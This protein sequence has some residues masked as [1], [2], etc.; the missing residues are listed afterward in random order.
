MGEITSITCD[1]PSANITML[2]CL[3]CDLEKNTIQYKTYFKHPST[4]DKVYAILDP[5]HMLKL[6]RNTLGDLKSFLDDE[7]KPVE[8][9]YIEKLYELQKS[10]GLSLAVKLRKG[11]ME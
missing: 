2:K 11:H 4:D 5:C 9:K 3:G 7:N 1:G 6:M 10:E 8:W